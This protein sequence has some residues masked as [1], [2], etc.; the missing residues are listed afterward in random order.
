M[1]LTFSRTVFVAS[2]ALSLLITATEANDNDTFFCDGNGENCYCSPA[3]TISGSS[4]LSSAD[5]I[6]FCGGGEA[7]DDVWAQTI[8]TPYAY[9]PNTYNIQ[10]DF[11][12]GTCGCQP[13]CNDPYLD[14]MAY[15]AGYKD[16]GGNVHSDTNVWAANPDPSV[17]WIPQGSDTK[18]DYFVFH[19]CDGSGLQSDCMGDIK[20]VERI[21]GLYSDT[22]LGI[23]DG[24][25]TIPDEGICGNYDDGRTYCKF[26]HPG[27]MRMHDNYVGGWF[28][29]PSDAGV[30]CASG[31][32]D[33]G[34][35]CIWDG[36]CKSAASGGWD[37]N[38]PLCDTILDIPN[39]Y[40]NGQHPFADVEGYHFSFALYPW[41]CDPSGD[42]TNNLFSYPSI[43]KYGYKCYVDNEPD[44]APLAL[45]VYFGVLTSDK[46]IKLYRFD[47]DANFD[48]NFINPGAP[49]TVY[50]VN[51]GAARQLRGSN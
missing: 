17:W 34:A 49:Y 45:E 18:Q 11:D 48:V 50:S 12:K 28:L 46:E 26:V 29:K 31:F 3:E 42:D 27:T 6:N 24:V 39:T 10:N 37:K 41:R 40:F 15:G 36:L 8:C 9:K 22:K 43:S 30:S 21:Q 5:N 20:Y 51:Q 47:S 4:P 44:P 1:N 35:G 23:T 25:G 38:N 33:E 7:S 16:E 19:G 13:N 32:G 2:M 14:V